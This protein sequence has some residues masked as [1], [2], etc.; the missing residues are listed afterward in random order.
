MLLSHCYWV[1]YGVVWRDDY[2]GSCRG[3]LLLLLVLMWKKEHENKENHKSA[4]R[5]LFI[6]DVCIT[7]YN[8]RRNRSSSSRNSHSISGRLS[9]VSLCRLNLLKLF[10]ISCS[11]FPLHRCLSVS[12]SYILHKFLCFY[13]Y[14]LTTDLPPH[15]VVA[16]NTN[17]ENPEKSICFSLKLKSFRAV[18]LLNANFL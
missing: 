14:I 17:K 18:C 6:W 13:R 12:S 5:D 11:L 16:K 7:I 4:F 10:M 1:W 8:R 2:V 15:R 3:P 9:L